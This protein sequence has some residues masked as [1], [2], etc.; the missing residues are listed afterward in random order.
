MNMQK[1]LFFL[2]PVMF[3]LSCQTANDGGLI[4]VKVALD[5]PTELSLSA[6]ADSIHPLILETSDSCLLGYIVKIERSDN[7][8]F[9]YDFSGPKVTRF[10]SDGKFL[11]KVGN[12][13]KGPGEYPNIRSFTVDETSESVFIASSRKLIS[14]DFSGAFKREVSLPNLYTEDMA[15]ID[16][17]LWLVGNEF[18]KEIAEG[19]YVARTS[20]LKIDKDLNI[21]DKLVIQDVLSEPGDGASHPGPFLLSGLAG[22]TYMY[23]PVLLYEPFL[24]DTLFK[25]EEGQLQASMKFDFAT[26]KEMKEPRKQISILNIYKSE[27]FSFLE[28]AY[29]RGKYFLVHDSASGNTWNTEG[30]I[31]DDYYNTGKV[32]L[33]P[34]DEKNGLFY[35]TKDA[36]SL[37]GNLEGVKESDNPVLFLVQLMY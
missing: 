17:K 37:E 36:Y 24:R 19:K 27:R 35:F 21:T 2:M 30:G 33:R 20:L 34:L 7:S 1:M 18:G 3:L 31:Y 32:L 14:Y 10:D 13:G 6:I 5:K 8:F 4:K 23:S 15:Y 11:N 28:Y 16:N 25:I 12:V 29:N 9:I 22:A 26:E